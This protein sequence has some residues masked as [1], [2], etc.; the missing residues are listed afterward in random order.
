MLYLLFGLAITAG[1]IVFLI[2][3]GKIKDSYSTKRDS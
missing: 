1:V 2:K 3:K